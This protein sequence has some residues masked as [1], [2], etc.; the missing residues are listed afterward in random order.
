MAM[1]Y[2]PIPSGFINV[3]A[4][5]SWG[6]PLTVETEPVTGDMVMNPDKTKDV[7]VISLEDDVK[8]A[9]QDLGFSEAPSTKQY[10]LKVGDARQMAIQLLFC[11]AHCGDRIA[12]GLLARLGE[13]GEEVKGQEFTE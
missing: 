13:V 12:K 7:I 4:G 9:E 8:G 11:L 1:P 5:H 6:P 3:E 2:H 10:A